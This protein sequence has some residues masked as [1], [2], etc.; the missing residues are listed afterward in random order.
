MFTKGLTDKVLDGTRMSKVLRI[1]STMS[2]KLDEIVKHLFGHMFRIFKIGSIT[3]EEKQYL[4]GTL[5]GVRNSIQ[6]QLKIWQD[7]KEKE[8]S[9]VEDVMR[10]RQ[11]LTEELEPVPPQVIW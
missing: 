3:L 5:T 8:R 6:D 2:S 10:F 7:T 9:E 11:M 1:I 4:V